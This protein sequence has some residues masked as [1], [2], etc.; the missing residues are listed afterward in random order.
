ME[1]KL[2]IFDA[3]LNKIIQYTRSYTPISPITEQALDLT[4]LKTNTGTGHIFYH[5]ALP[6]DNTTQSLVI[7]FSSTAAG[8][9]HVYD[10]GNVAGDFLMKIVSNPTKI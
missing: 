10:Y 9:D 4:Y 5:D 8:A 3:D 2:E 6:A 7:A 1:F